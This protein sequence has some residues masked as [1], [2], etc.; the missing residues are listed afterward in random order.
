MHVGHP[1]NVDITYMVTQRRTVQELMDHLPPDAPERS[2]FEDDPIFRAA[3]PTKDFNCWGVPS[4]AEPSFEKTDI[5]ALVLI[6]P[7]IGS[8]GGIAQIGIVKAKC[9]IRCYEASRILWPDT[10]DER[11][12]PF[13]FFFDME[14]GRRSWIQG[15]FW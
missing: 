5:G 13:I 14:V 8:E 3:F 1:G 2:F 12:F 9:P 10:P 7:S 11:L 15:P 6:V 4:R